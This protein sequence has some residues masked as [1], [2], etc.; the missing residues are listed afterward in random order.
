MNIEQAK[1]VLEREGY[2][3]TPP[4]T[5]ADMLGLMS[6]MH[7]WYEAD[8]MFSDRDKSTYN[9]IIKLIEDHTK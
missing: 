3:I 6:R 8:D 7:D 9:S 2:M 4:A 1:K 5:K